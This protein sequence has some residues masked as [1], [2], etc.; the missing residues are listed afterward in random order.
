MT[1]VLAAVGWGL[2]GAGALTHGLHRDRLTDL[3]TLHVGDRANALS[4]AVTIAEAAIAA[5]IVLG[6]L[7]GSHALVFVA[8]AAGAI[9]GLGFSVWVA[10]LWAS[11]SS[12]PCACSF[13]SAPTSV[14][15]MTRSALTVLIGLFLVSG[16]LPDLDGAASTVAGLAALLAGGAIG[17]ALFVL[18][19]AIA[20]PSYIGD[21][22]ERAA[23]QP[24]IGRVV[25]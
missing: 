8:A 9:L 22:K 4:L 19:D 21:M 20:W 2:F 6:V 3:L 1:F 5:A 12:L 25:E 24:V 23:S 14:W 7:T 11:D 18:P 17:F 16:P 15:S 13:S 10:R